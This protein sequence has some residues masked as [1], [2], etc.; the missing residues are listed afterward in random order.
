MRNEVCSREAKTQNLL[1]SRGYRILLE[2]E[3]QSKPEFTSLPS[4]FI[5]DW[6]FLFKQGRED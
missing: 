6:C 1:F 4:A 5:K 2:M 3:S